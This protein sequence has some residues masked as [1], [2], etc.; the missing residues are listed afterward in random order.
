M[1]ALLQIF[2]SQTC[3]KMRKERRMMKFFRKKQLVRQIPEQKLFGF[4]IGEDYLVTNKPLSF[5]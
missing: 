2:S 4:V 1:G 5:S 3:F